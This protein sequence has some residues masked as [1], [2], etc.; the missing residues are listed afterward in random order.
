M[1]KFYKQYCP[2][3]K[4]LDVIGDRWTL[5]IVR[6]LLR[7]KQR[8]KDLQASLSGIAPN[9][10]SD[11]LKKLEEAGLIVRQMFR[12]LPPR[13]EYDLTDKGRSLET[14]LHSLAQ[15]GMINMMDKPTRGEI[16]DPG[17]IFDAMPAVFLPSAAHG[18]KA[19]YRVDISGSQGGT[20]YVIISS[21]RCRVTTEDPTRVPDVWIKTDAKTWALLATG[22]I[23]PAVAES[24]G[25][26]DVTGNRDLAERFDRLFDKAVRSGQRAALP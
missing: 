22:L 24:S 25:L 11:R 1:A 6:D 20:W 2:V 3:A 10:L 17:F 18:V 14:V 19:T 26:L 5:L 21:K 9:L 15:F 23:E 16:L 12:Q 4:S 7:G 8:F 13:V